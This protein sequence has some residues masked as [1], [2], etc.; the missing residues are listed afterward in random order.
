MFLSMSRLEG[1]P[2]PLIEAMMSNAVPVASRT[3][4][5]SEIIRHGENGFIFDLDASAEDI[6]AM[7]ESAY[8][9]SGNVRATVEHLTWDNLSSHVVKLVQ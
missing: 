7:I 5:A 6:A 2:I 8:D 3:G 1:G 9:L 4:F